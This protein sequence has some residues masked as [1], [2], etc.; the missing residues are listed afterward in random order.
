[1]RRFGLVL[2]LAVIV[3]SGCRREPVVVQDR[4]SIEATITARPSTPI[5]TNPPAA[6]NLPNPDDPLTIVLGGEFAN[7][8]YWTWDNISNLLGTYSSYGAYE[9]VTVEGHTYTG[10]PLPFLLDYARVNQYSQTSVVITRD[11]G[12]FSYSTAQMRD[13]YSC[14]IVREDNGTLTLV[15][16][17]MTPGVVFSLMRIDAR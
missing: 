10:V 3:L 7:G 5:P 15:L 6:P 13:C 16:P 11:L 12:R 14:L 2:F 8:G 4:V 17:Q 1:M 9:S